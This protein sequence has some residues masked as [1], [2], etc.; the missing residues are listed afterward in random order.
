MMANSF[1]FVGF[2]HDGVTRT[3]DRLLMY[4]LIRPAGQL[5]STIAD[6]LIGSKK[7]RHGNTSPEHHALICERV[8]RFVSCGEPI[9]VFAMWGANKGYGQVEDRVSVDLADVLGLRRFVSLNEQVKTLYSPGLRIRICC[10]D[11][12]EELLNRHQLNMRQKMTTYVTGLRNLARIMS[13]GA[14]TVQ[15]ETEILRQLDQNKCEFVATAKDLGVLFEHYWF[16]SEE[17]PEDQRESLVA[18]RHLA[19]AG[20]QGGVENVAREYY[21]DRARNENPS[22]GHSGLVRQVCTYL[23]LALARR[24]AKVDTGLSHDTNGYIPPIRANFQPYPPGSFASHKTARL[25]YKVKDSKNSHRV[26][27]PWCGFGFASPAGEQWDVTLATLRNYA[28]Y[29]VDPMTIVATDGDLH[30]PVRADVLV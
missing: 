27:T 23:G 9:E 11:I 3:L 13:G 21:I 29:K 12:G 25:E 4:D 28:E 20:W 1:Q 6:I 30:Q 10:E 2:A 19:R 22:L 24:K 26:V 15:E 7:I 14:I 5:V 8:Q 18:H 16:D 17:V